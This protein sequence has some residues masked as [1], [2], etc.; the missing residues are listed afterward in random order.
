MHRK[1]A[2]TAGFFITNIAIIFIAAYALVAC[3]RGI[4]DS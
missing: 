3:A 2:K 1:P 4:F